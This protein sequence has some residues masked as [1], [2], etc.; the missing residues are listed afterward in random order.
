MQQIRFVEK[1][2][3]PVIGKEGQ[4]IAGGEWIRALWDDANSHFAEIM[5]LI[6]RDRLGRPQVWGVMSDLG[7]GFKPWDARGGLYLAGCEVR[8]DAEPPEG[9]T[10]WTVPGYRYAVAEYTEGTYGEVFDSV[11]RG[12]FPENGLKLAGAVHEFYPPSG[13]LELWFPVEKR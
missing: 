6:L 10:K 1:P 8:P 5:P 7:R 12:Y 4:G 11:L 9:W 2:A 3:F 13:A